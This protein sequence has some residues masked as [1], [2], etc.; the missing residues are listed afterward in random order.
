MY[1]YRIYSNICSGDLDL[2]HLVWALN[3]SEFFFAKI[4]PK[5]KFII[6]DLFRLLFLIILNSVR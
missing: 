3:L 6:F 1:M 2:S 4:N 5:N